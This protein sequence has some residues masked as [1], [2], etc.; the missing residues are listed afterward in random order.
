MKH[1]VYLVPHTA[2]DAPIP[3]TIM[4]CDVI[5]REGEWLALG[6]TLFT[7]EAVV[8]KLNAGALEPYVTQLRLTRFV[9]SESA[10]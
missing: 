9:P 4:V 6:T 5:P 2:A 7:V 3:L 10:Q 8:H 1:S